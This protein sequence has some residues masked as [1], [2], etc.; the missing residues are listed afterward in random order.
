MTKRIQRL[1]AFLTVTTLLAGCRSMPSALH[2][3]DVTFAAIRPLLEKQ[4]SAE[5]AVLGVRNIFGLTPDAVQVTT[6]D[7]AMLTPVYGDD[8]KVGDVPVSWE[9]TQGAYDLAIRNSHARWLSVTYNGRQLK[10]DQV[11]GCLGQ[12]DSYWAYIHPGHSPSVQ[13]AELFMFY[14]KPGFWV[15]VDR[16]STGE[17]APSFDG[18]APVTQIW[19]VPPSSGA[20]VTT[21]FTHQLAPTSPSSLAG[22]I[23]SWPGKWEDLRFSTAY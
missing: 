7:E 6:V 22:Q 15:R 11:F 14:P 9:T 21:A 4:L 10:V 18:Q 16:D 1:V 23:R 17:R 3:E 5:Q 20:N 19:F 2:C 12:P 13:S 8:V